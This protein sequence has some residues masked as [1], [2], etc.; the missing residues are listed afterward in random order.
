MP[1]LVWHERHLVGFENRLKDEDRIKAKVAESLAVKGRT[2]AEAM[3]LIPDAIRYTFQYHEA[4]YSRHALE[5]IALMQERN[6][7]L[8]R[9]GNF[10]R[11]RQ[12]KGISSVWRHRDTG[13]LLETQFHTEASYHAMMFT[14]EFSY[15]RL[16][17][18]Q[19][20]AQEELELEAFQR[21][22]YAH[23]PVPPG[24]DDIP[25]Y[26]ARGDWEIPGRPAHQGDGLTYYA[27][28]DDFS[29]RERPAGVLRRS[30]IDN[31][32]R[33]ETLTQELA[34]HRSPLLISAERG[35][36][37]NE[38]ILITEEEAARIRDMLFTSH[39]TPRTGN[40]QQ[41]H[42]SVARTAVPPSPGSPPVSRRGRTRLTADDISGTPV[43]FAKAS[44]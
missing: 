5:D 41:P 31:G 23:V 38:F 2:V 43:L 22:V 3:K 21:E 6:S 36:L 18:A 44:G 4:D 24:A 40:W 42:R 1:E 13:Q 8:V 17:S 39:C 29:S 15:A 26:P 34:W 12:Y 28:V 9:L 25:G 27:I 35:D 14:A 33:D 11:G 19:T 30:Y 32:R 10:W 7:D 16:R 20:C 37:E